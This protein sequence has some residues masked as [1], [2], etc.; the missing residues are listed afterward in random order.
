MKRKRHRVSKEGRAQI[1]YGL[2]AELDVTGYGVTMT[3][4]ARAMGLQPSTYVTNIL[5]DLH[6][7]REVTYKITE[8]QNG[9]IV[10]FW[11]VVRPGGV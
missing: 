5:W 3:M 9:G 11:A 8:L 6:R 10:R 7:S 2:V 1:I 4:I